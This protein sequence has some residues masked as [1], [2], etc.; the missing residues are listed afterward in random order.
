MHAKIALAGGLYANDANVERIAKNFSQPV[1][2]DFLAVLLLRP[3][4]W[5]SSESE[6]SENLPV[7]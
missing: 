2:A 3:L 4:T 7:E 5:S 1:H 6:S